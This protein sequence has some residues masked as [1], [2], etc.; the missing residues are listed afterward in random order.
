MLFFGEIQVE[1]DGFY[2][3][4]VFF[5]GVFF[6]IFFEVEVE[7]L[8]FSDVFFDISVS[9]VI[10][11]LGISVLDIMGSGFIFMVEFIGSVIIL[12]DDLL[13]KVFFM[14]FFL[15]CISDIEFK[16]FNLIFIEDIGGCSLVEFIIM[17]MEM[18]Y[19]LLG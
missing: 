8:F 17:D 15:N 11:F 2:F 9:N 12:L 7:F 19:C 13:G 14:L 16:F 18:E 1:V 4:E 3:I 6:F 10:I 5:L